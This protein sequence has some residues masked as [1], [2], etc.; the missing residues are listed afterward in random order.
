[1]TGP[2][3]EYQADIDAGAFDAMLLPG[4]RHQHPENSRCE[5]DGF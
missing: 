3:K 1:M 4:K 5:N 2:V